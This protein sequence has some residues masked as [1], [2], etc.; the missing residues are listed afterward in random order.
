MPPAFVQSKGGTSNTPGSLPIAYTS[1]NTAGNLLVCSGVVNTSTIGGLTITDTQGNTWI[2]ALHDTWNSVSTF[3]MAYA[4]NCKAGANT[5]TI[6]QLGTLISGAVSEYS[7]VSTTTPLDEAGFSDSGLGTWTA[8]TSGNVTTRDNGEL[9][10]A[11]QANSTGPASVTLGSG[12]SNLQN[13]SGNFVSI[14]SQVQAT[15]GAIAGTFTISASSGAC[16][17][18]TFVPAGETAFNVWVP[19]GNV[20]ANPGGHKLGNPSVIPGLTGVVLGGTV[21]GGWFG[22]DLT[23]NFYY[24]E[25]VDGLTTWTAYASNPMTPAGAAVYYP[26]V[27]N[28]GST[29]YL[30]ACTSSVE[31]GS[32]SGIAVYT[33][34]SQTG[35]WTSHGIQIPIGA[36]GAWDSGG[37]FQLNIVDIIAGTWYAYYSGYNGVKFGQGLATSTDGIH[38][39]KSVS[40]PIFAGPIGNMTFLKVSSSAYYAYAPFPSP[41]AALAAVNNNPTGRWFSTSPSGPWTQLTYSGTLVPV[42]YVSTASELNNSGGLPGA[43]ANDLRMVVANG[44]IYLY[45]TLT[46]TGGVE[47]SVNAALASGYT[48]AQ[49]TATYEGVFNVPFTGLSLNLTTLATDNFARANANPIGGNWTAIASGGGLGGSQILS[50]VVEPASLANPNGTSY[51]NAISWPNDQWATITAVA[52][53]NNS[54]VLGSGVRENTSGSPNLYLV[55]WNPSSGQLGQ[56]GVWTMVKRNAGT[57]TTLATGTGMV[58][59]A[60]DT[61][62][63]VVIGT[64]I[65]LYWNGY[66]VAAATD[67]ALTSGAA[68]L[69]NAVVTALSDSQLNG[70]SGGSFQA[71][72]PIPSTSGNGSLMML[73]CGS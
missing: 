39:T 66:L 65:Y 36:G 70:W 3:F 54:A 19:Q 7:G 25:S 10:V 67:S 69:V 60:S 22:D 43:N 44:N 27:Y 21:F 5:V 29:Y 26:T 30:Y 49:L 20:V 42:Y 52:L 37:A 61:I 6:A 47:Q 45:Y 62:T 40:N 59:S 14:E 57:A 53:A 31:G 24:Y 16:G 50:D 32:A 18:L 11:A 73:G 8:A 28:S 35:P 41:N 34:T 38:W 4:P 12:F 51:Y 56:S 46:F 48:P 55:K 17:V 2:I 13:D 58:V 15:A 68:G 33:A 1:N 23:G 72:P 64:N 9:I 71:A 63:C